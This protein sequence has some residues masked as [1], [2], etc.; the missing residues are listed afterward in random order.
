MAVAL[1]GMYGWTVARQAAARLMTACRYDPDTVSCGLLPLRKER[2]AKQRA[3]TTQLHLVIYSHIVNT[4]MYSLQ[5]RQPSM[6]G[7]TK[8]LQN[9]RVFIWARK[10]VIHCVMKEPVLCFP[11][12][13]FSLGKM[14]VTMVWDILYHDN[15]VYYN[16]VIFAG[17]STQTFYILLENVEILF[18]DNQ[19]NWIL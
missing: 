15:W 14:L 17:K 5:T 7:A 4:E 18:F 16:L 2:E 19:L 13:G 6:L 9:I 8:L 1:A 12:N 11:Y 3:D 10:F